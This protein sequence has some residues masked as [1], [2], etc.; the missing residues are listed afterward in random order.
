MAGRTQAVT[1]FVL[2]VCF[3]CVW[4]E[5]GTVY[6]LDGLQHCTEVPANMSGIETVALKITDLDPEKLYQIVPVGGAVMYWPGNAAQ[7]YDHYAW[8]MAITPE[9][10]GMGT[11]T[12]APLCG[13]SDEW[14]CC[15]YSTDKLGSSPP[16]LHAMNSTTAFDQ[17][18][19]NQV[20]VQGQSTLWVWFEDDNC[21]NN[22]GTLLFEITDVTPSQ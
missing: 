19:N 15:W 20:Y 17:V 16:L 6:K 10:C 22:H 13:S 3:G 14:T 21:S 5:S 1:L 12:L 9:N 8:A 2:V 11:E 7:D 4:G 18:A